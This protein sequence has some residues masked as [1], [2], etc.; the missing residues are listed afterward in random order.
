MK[1][2]WPASIPSTPST[3]PRVGKR[4]RLFEMKD[5]QDPIEHGAEGT[6]IHVGGEVIN[7][8]WDGGRSLGLID[9]IDEFEIID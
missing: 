5:E 4:V 2:E 1:R 7:V 3:D 9:G 8:D 6:V